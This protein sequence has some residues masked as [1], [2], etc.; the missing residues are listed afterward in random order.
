VSGFL[1]HGVV[2]YFSQETAKNDQSVLHRKSVVN[3]LIAAN[4]SL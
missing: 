1:R 2:V 3:A 4:H